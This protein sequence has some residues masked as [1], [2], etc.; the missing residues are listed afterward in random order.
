MFHL[1]K[2]V[3][4][5]FDNRISIDIDRVVISKDYGISMLSTLDKIAYGE[6]FDKSTSISELIGQGKTY[7]N[8]LSFFQRLNAITENTGKR[9]VVYADKNSFY[10]LASVWLKTVCPNINAEAAHEVVNLYY[11][12][13]KIYGLSPHVEVRRNYQIDSSEYN[14]DKQKFAEIYD[15][16]V[17]DR[18]NYT[19]FVESVTD[20]LSL[21]YLLASYLYDGS[22]KN[23]LKN[24]VFAITNTNT[25]QFLFETKSYLTS[26]IGRKAFQTLLGI[27]GDN[28]LESVM[29]HTRI[30]HW[31]DSSIWTIDGIGDFHEKSKINFQAIDATTLQKFKDDMVLIHSEWEHIDPNCDSFKRIDFIQ[32]VIDGEFSDEEFDQAIDFELNGNTG[33]TLLRNHEK[34]RVNFYLLDYIIDSFNS[35][36]KE[37]LVPYKLL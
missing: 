36:K 8:Y 12:K 28:S 5:N 18:K 37:K 22:F 27:T 7:E 20:S 13:D 4:L 21:E 1:F 32:T 19:A 9:V 26:N 29:N 15:G 14:I 35:G 33:C 30:S 31:F 34:D 16:V 17:L 6:L 24:R 2:K 23:P 11:I 3:Y 10:E 25:Q